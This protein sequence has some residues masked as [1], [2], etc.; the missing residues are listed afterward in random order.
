MKIETCK[1]K[2]L[3]GTCRAGLVVG[4]TAVLCLLAGCAVTSINGLYDQ[5][6]QGKDPDLVVEPGLVGVWR[7]TDSKCT[8]ILTI[9]LNA[10]T[11]HLQVVEHG[12]GCKDELNK[13]RQQARLIKLDANYFLDISPLPNDVC[14]LCLAKHMIFLI[15]F[16]K[17]SL[18]LMAIN[19]DWWKDGQAAKT[20][21]LTTLPDDSYTITASTGEMK[22]FFRKLGANPDVFKEDAKITFKRE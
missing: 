2:K 16:D 14:D 4:L 20:I 19:Y 13:T 6:S 1:S 18:S 17:Q 12:S 7:M 9:G 8:A 11:Y 15:Q 22:H 10:K 21:P 5:G 3:M